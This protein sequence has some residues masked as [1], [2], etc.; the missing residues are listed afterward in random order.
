LLNKKLQDHLYIIGLP[1]FPITQTHQCEQ[2]G[3]CIPDFLTIDGYND[4]LDGSDEGKLH[5]A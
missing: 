5:K 4:C 3:V 2:S 1:L